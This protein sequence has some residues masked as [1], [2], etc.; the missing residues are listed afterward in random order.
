MITT[1]PAPSPA[2]APERHPVRW[3]ILAIVLVAEVMD[4][5]DATIVNVLARPSAPIS[6]AARPRCNGSGPPTRSR[7]PS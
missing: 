5:V 2:A 1:A 4:L 6:V 7:S 3:A